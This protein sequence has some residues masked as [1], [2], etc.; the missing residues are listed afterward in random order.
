M[1][2]SPLGRC[3]LPSP[4]GTCGRRLCYGPLPCWVAA[5]FQVRQGPAVGVFAM[6]RSPL[7]RCRLPSPT[8]ACGR[9][10]C[11]GPLPVGSLEAAQSDRDLRSASF[12]WAAPR[13]V[14]RG[15]PVRQGPAVSVFSM[16]R[17]PLGRCRLPSP[18]G[19][20]GR[21]LFYGPLP[22]GRWRLPSP[23][24]TKR[25][26]SAPAHP[27]CRTTKAQQVFVRRVPRWTLVDKIARTHIRCGTTFG[28]KEI[29]LRRIL[30]RRVAANR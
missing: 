17:S 21:R 8:G 25:S 29:D 12:L 26:S 5:G 15:C 18:T 20:C 30:E 7:G 6:A 1:A 13:W 11:Y 27:Q 16:A 19:T 3:R 28:G 14:A 2:R 10:L 24:A 4:T 23:A 22:I 9:R